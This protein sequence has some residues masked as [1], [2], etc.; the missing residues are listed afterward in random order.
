MKAQEKLNNILPAKIHNDEKEKNKEPKHNMPK[1]TPYKRKG[2]KLEC[3]NHKD[4]ISSEE[5][6][7]HHT[8]KQQDSNISSDDN[9]KKKKYKPY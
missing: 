6:V 5:S 9:K 3:S 8:Q 7:K 1:K 2:R 4:E